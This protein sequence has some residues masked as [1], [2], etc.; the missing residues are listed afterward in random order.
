[1]LHRTRHLFIRQQTSVTNAIRAHLAE[2]GVTDAAV[3]PC[4]CADWRTAVTVLAPVARRP[5]FVMS[6][7]A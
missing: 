2:F 7:V 4:L 5:N 1:M 6:L 3:S